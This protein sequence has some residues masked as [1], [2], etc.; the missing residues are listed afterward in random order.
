[1]TTPRPVMLRVNGPAPPVMSTFI[2]DDCPAQIG[3][4]PVNES[5]ALVGAGG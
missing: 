5:T 1:L 3:V 2:V 4:V